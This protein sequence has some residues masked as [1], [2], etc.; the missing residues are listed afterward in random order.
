LGLLLLYTQGAKPP[1]S[2][3]GLRLAARVLVGVQAETVELVEDAGLGVVEDAGVADEEADVEMTKLAIVVDRTSDAEE[4]RL[5]ELASDV[6]VAMLD[7]TTSEDKAW[8]GE[9]VDELETEL[10]VTSLD[11]ERTGAEENEEAEAA[12]VEEVDAVV[13]ELETDVLEENETA[14]EVE[15]TNVVDADEDEH[16][17]KPIWQLL[18]QCASLEPLHRLAH[19]IL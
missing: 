13:A 2:N 5:E 9:G 16:W 4:T 8:D 17:P 3:E 10:D 15:A 18:P 1:V 7:R 19:R 6:V 12:P 14:G 11:V